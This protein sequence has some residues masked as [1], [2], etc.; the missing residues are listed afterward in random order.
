MWAGRTVVI[1]A[2]GP[3]LTPE[4]IAEAS[5]SSAVRVVINTTYKSFPSADLLYACDGTWW[6][7]YQGA[8]DFP[9]AK[10]S[11]D[12]PA[13]ER[14][15]L[16]RVRAAV[17]QAFSLD[18]TRIGTGANS[19]FQAVNIA[20]LAGAARVLLIGFDMGLDQ[21][22]THHHGDHPGGLNNPNEAQ[23]ERWRSAFEDAAETLRR[24]NHPVEIV[25]CSRRTALSC[26]PRGELS[27]CLES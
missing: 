22:R 27:A 15:G 8:P 23:A 17:G 7:A 25:N 1:A 11:Q 10:W 9:G 16:R 20:V 6:D 21:G 24:A 4:Q 5:A 18:P 3:S 12:G 13:S 14:Y 26:F 2:S 19:G